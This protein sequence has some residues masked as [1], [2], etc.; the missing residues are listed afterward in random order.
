MNT[1]HMVS[2]A[3]C[4]IG[5]ST[6][7]AGDITDDDFSQCHHYSSLA[8]KYQAAKQADKSLDEILVGVDDRAE[9]QLATQ[10][11][12]E[13]DQRYRPSEIRKRLFDQCLKSFAVMREN[14][15]HS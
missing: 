9:R 6:A 13:V 3:L 14:E 1:K 4:C 11:Y 12:Q 2:L 5:L 15:R 10:I 7:Y 8:A